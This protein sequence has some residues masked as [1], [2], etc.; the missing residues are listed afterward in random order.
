MERH[1]MEA[2][3]AHPLPPSYLAWSILNTF[4]CCLP[5]GIAAI[6]Y[7]KKVESANTHGDIDRARDASQTA[8]TL[9]IAALIC[10]I[11]F[12]TIYLSIKLTEK[13]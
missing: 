9:N 7:S 11:I 4:C 13:K 1:T 8:K 2:G 12:I 10:G 6:I 5:L 3:Q